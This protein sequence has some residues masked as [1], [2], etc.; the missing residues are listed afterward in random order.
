M[1]SAKNILRTTLFTLTLLS[2][3]SILFAQAP[4]KG[5]VGLRTGYY[6]NLGGKN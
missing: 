1:M 6:G 2:A 3:S 4:Y 5:A